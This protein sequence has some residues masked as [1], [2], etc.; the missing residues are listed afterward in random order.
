MNTVNAAKIVTNKAA[1]VVE[2]VFVLLLAAGLTFI[3]G[4]I[5]LGQSTNQTVVSLLKEAISSQK[6]LEE[7]FVSML[8]EASSSQRSLDNEAEQRE[9]ALKAQAWKASLPLLS[10]TQLA[11]KYKANLFAANRDY[12]G[13]TFKVVGRV[14]RIDRSIDG[15]P[16]LALETHSELFEILF[17]PTFAFKAAD[18]SR[19]SQVP[20]DSAVQL[21]CV[22]REAKSANSVVADCEFE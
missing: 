19:L 4:L 18:I 5:A 3:V 22:G 6:G 1:V 11:R 17:S 9:A 21:I 10:S 2:V 7:I 15:V 16:Y 14:T 20:V 8:K 13:K 12:A